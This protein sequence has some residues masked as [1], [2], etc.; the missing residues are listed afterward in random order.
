MSEILSVKHETD[1]CREGKLR[2]AERRNLLGDIDCLSFES[3]LP[4]PPGRSTN[5]LFIFHFL[6]LNS[7]LIANTFD[8]DGSTVSHVI[9]FSHKTV[10]IIFG[11]DYKTNWCEKLNVSLVLYMLYFIK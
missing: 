2:W 11:L 6:V 1:T 3:D 10:I 7:Q 9:Y 5:V 8:I 4:K